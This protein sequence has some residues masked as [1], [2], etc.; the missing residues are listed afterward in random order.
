VSLVDLDTGEI[1]DI[2]DEES[3]RAV[4]N[5]IRQCVAVAHEEIVHAYKGRAWTAMG[6]KSWDDYCEG[7]FGGARLPIPKADRSEVVALLR[8]E[9]MSTRAI[10]SAV[11]VSVGTV[12]ADLSGVQNRTP[13]AVVGADGKTYP[14]QQPERDDDRGAGPVDDREVPPS[15]EPAAGAPRP[16][17]EP[18]QHEDDG[19]AEPPPAA[20]S[21]RPAPMTA[22]E[23]RE[24]DRLAAIDRRRKS[25]AVVHSNWPTIESLHEHPHR[26]EILAGL[27]EG[28]RDFILDLE[29]RITWKT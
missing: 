24:I 8:A 23:Q 16:A 22:E 5:R 18:A 1:V 13:D 19:A 27:W 7:E 28:D 4:T 2:L 14:A 3:A 10:S 15:S 11:G 9:G 25:I 12:H 6:Y 20:P 21:P 26:D 17:P 29:R